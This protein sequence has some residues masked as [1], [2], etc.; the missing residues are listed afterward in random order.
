LAISAADADRFAR[1]F[2]PND[3]EVMANIKFDR[4]APLSS[5]RDD[6]TAI[7]SI[8]PRDIPFVVF[9]SIRHE[10]ES[11]VKKILLEIA[12]NRPQIV[13]GV[14]PRHLQRLKFWQ[15][16]L[17][18]LKIRWVLRSAVSKPVSAGTLILW[19]TFGELMSAYRLAQSAFVGGSLAPLG[20]QNFLEA[21]INGVIPVIG[22]S[23]ENFAWVGQGIL[24]TGLLRVADDWQ[25]TAALILQDLDS[26]RPRTSVIA[27]AYQFIKAR[28]GGTDQA[29][30]QIE[31]I[32]FEK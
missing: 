4:M 17:N 5:V 28:Q 32:L 25:Q 30:R 24:D 8:L 7:E 29:C 16:G 13:T 19:D 23:W 21:I 11:E 26:P 15:E 10:E 22:P 20:G 9:A 12:S 27:R 31:S 1:L 18:Q 14:F 6:R 2:G 3:V